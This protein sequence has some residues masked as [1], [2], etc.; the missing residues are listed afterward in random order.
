VRGPGQNNLDL[1][2][3]K[4]FPIYEKLRLQFR[5]DAFNTLN[6]TQFTAVDNNARFDLTGKQVNQA[7]S[8][9]TSAAPSRRLV[10]GVKF[11]F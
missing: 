8:Q 3:A 9:Y 1:S 5:A 6:H 10:L 4:T 7:F 11:Y 2:I